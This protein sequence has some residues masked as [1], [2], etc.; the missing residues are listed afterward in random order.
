LLYH[1]NFFGGNGFPT[2][3]GTPFITIFGNN[4]GFQKLS[5]SR[6]R[7]Y[8][9]EKESNDVSHESVN[10][11]D[12]SFTPP[13]V[14]LKNISIKPLF[15]KMK[16]E[17]HIKQNFVIY[18]GPILEANSCIFSSINPNS[19]VNAKYR[20]DVVSFSLTITAD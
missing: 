16:N 12:Q 11:L 8:D 15:I 19:Q 10:E 18:Y 1:I 14:S 6:A 3:S 9:D 17:N 13:K 4:L 5:R 7:N 2:V 20:F